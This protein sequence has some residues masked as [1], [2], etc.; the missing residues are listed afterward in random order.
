MPFIVRNLGTVLQCTYDI[1]RPRDIPVLINKAC[2]FPTGALTLLQVSPFAAMHIHACIYKRPACFQNIVFVFKHLKFE[3][4][5]PLAAEL[6]RIR[7]HE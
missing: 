5:S 4:S 2:P 7:I 3:E 1:N 6:K